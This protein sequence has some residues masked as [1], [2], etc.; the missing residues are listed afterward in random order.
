MPWWTTRK[1]ACKWSQ[2]PSLLLVSYKRHARKFTSKLLSHSSSS[3]SRNNALE[4]VAVGPSSAGVAVAVAAE[5]VAR[6]VA[7][8]VA[9]AV[10][11][12][13]VV[14]A[15]AVAASNSLQ[16]SSMLNW[17]T[18]TRRPLADRQLQF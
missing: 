4:A 13:V 3:F 17:I 9:A 10:V 5:A 15:E 11:A 6:L 14:A 8:A 7:V 12:V 1:S 18:G 16:K 2:L